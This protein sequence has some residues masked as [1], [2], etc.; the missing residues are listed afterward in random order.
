MTHATRRYERTARV[1]EVV[2][3]VLADELERLSDPRL[4]FVTVTGVEVTPDLRQATVYYS[5]LA[6]AGADAEAQAEAAD[7][8]AAALRSATAHLQAEI[9][10]QVRMKYTPHLVFREDPAIR[11]GERVDE[12]LRRLHSDGEEGEEGQ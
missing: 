5:A 7:E 6:P 9:G 12:I 3:E 1:N 2:R 4:G 11:T 10:R 8:T